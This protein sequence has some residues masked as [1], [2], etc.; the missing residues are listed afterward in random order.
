MKEFWPRYDAP[1][2]PNIKSLIAQLA[3]SRYPEAWNEEKQILQFDEPMGR[4][5]EDIAPI[6]DEE[7]KIPEIAHFLKLNPEHLKGD[8][9]CCVARLDH[10]AAM[11]FLQRTINKTLKKVKRA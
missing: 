4:L 6:S 8:E 9:L 3:L 11:Y 10:T 1:T 2:P 5:L 7:L